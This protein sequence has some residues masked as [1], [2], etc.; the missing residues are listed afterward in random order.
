MAGLT[1]RPQL[2]AARAIVVL[3]PVFGAAGRSRM[4]GPFS[5]LAG[6]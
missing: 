4:V 1:M 2:T 6:H 3:P 5:G